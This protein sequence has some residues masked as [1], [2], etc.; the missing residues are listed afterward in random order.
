M[1]MSNQIEPFALLDDRSADDFSPR[2]RLYTC[3]QHT[4]KCHHT[5]DL[6][7]LFNK[8]KVAQSEGLHA[9]GFFAYE[10]GQ[11]LMGLPV[12]PEA[13]VLAEVMLFEKCERLKAKDV[14]AW[15]ARHRED[16]IGH[17][18]VANIKANVDEADFFNAINHIHNYI[19]A[20]DVYQ[21]NYTYRL[22]FEAYGSPVALYQRLIARQPVPFGALALRPDGLFV[23]SQSPEL[24]LKKSGR[25]L[26]SMPMKGTAAAHDESL[27]NA[28]AIDGLKNC[29][30][31]R[32]ENLMIVDMLRNDLGRVAEVGSVKTRDLF[33]VER[34]GD[35]LQMTST[36]SAA[37]D[38]KK[39][40]ADIFKSVFPC[41]SITGAPKHRAMQII[42]KVES[43]PRGLYTGAIGWFD[44][45]EQAGEDGDFCLSVP[46]RTM[47]LSAL[48]EGGV[49]QGVLGVGAG[50]V[51][52][53]E[54]KKEYEECLLKAQ[55]LSALP[56]T[57]ELFET[58]RASRERGCVYADL[59]CQRME[60]SAQY[61]G[62]AFDVDAVRHAIE[63]VCVQLPDGEYRL[64]LS[65]N[66]SG[67][68]IQHA[69]LSPLAD[70]PSVI[71]NAE[72]VLSA[73]QLFLRHK[74][75][76]RSAYDAAWR[77]AETKGA[78]DMLFFNARG[79][80]TEGGRS[81]VF[82]KL[83]DQWFTPPLSVGVLP[84]VMRGILLGDP[85]WAA[86]EKVLRIEDLQRAEAVVICNALRGAMH[87]T[88]QFE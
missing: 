74:T 23:L 33:T 37:L 63:T 3:W 83:A 62:M 21:I 10:L 54:A 27:L 35:V 58:M 1:N 36:V 9:V 29:Q 61:F 26:T 48:G 43:A 34:Y 45:P 50:I 86:E 42:D 51:Y 55:Y 46:I 38:D 60:K 71:V 25:T 30:K 64:R 52:D 11:G 75:S 39:S 4:L 24:F 32:A 81:N 76:V 20:G 78:F 65:L 6:P 15:I 66:A 84:G 85:R 7:T 28:Q 68:S 72:N 70:R 8:T 87:A 41:A 88:L 80:L 31:N 22:N 47:T 44:A 12:S 17:A 16:E 5:E 14:D 57:F 18:G 2:S 73:N 53:S 13:G 67:F 40:F 49:R 77:L 59:H 19:Q 79:E 69:L 56:P 82:L